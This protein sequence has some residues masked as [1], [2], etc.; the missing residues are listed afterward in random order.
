VRHVSKCVKNPARFL[1]VVLCD[2]VTEFPEVWIRF[3]A[4]WYILLKLSKV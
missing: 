3:C 2:V 4:D 1:D